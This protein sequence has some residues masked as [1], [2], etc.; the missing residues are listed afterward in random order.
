MRNLFLLFVVIVMVSLLK[1][2]KKPVEV[3]A[4]KVKS[5]KME[6]L[7]IV[8][9]QQLDFSGTLFLPQTLPMSD[10]FVNTGFRNITVAGKNYQYVKCI[11]GF[12][13][14][15]VAKEVPVYKGQLIKVNGPTKLFFERE[16]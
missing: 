11:S 16:I 9:Q 1:E 7:D 6:R 13:L 10:Y 8:K 2:V 12:C 15:G 3:P 4:V 14:A 5:Y